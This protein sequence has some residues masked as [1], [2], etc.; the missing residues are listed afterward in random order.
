MVKPIRIVHLITSLDVGGAEMMLYRLLACLKRS[1]YESR[2]ISLLPAGSVGEKIAEQGVPVLSL[3]M[4]PGQP[5]LGAFS[6]LV[7]ELRQFQP[8]ILQTWLYHADLMGL[9]AG[10]LAG[11]PD[12]IWN[13]RASDADMSRYR[14]LSGWT[15]RACARLASRPRAVITNS[16]A[17]RIHHEKIGY[18]PR[19]WVLISNGVDIERFKPDLSARS[20]VR[21][22][23]GLDADTFLIGYIARYDPLKDHLTFL[24]AAGH[25]T[26]RYP[27]AHFL[28][29]GLNISWDNHE[30]VSFIDS[31]RLRPRVHLLGSRDD[32]PRI[33]AALDIATSASISEGFSNV[34]V[35][36][37]ACGVPCV[38]TNV[39]DSADIVGETGV[40]VQP[41]DPLALAEGWMQLINASNAEQK[42]LGNADRQRVR[43]RF[44]LDRITRQYEDLYQNIVLV[45]RMVY[46]KS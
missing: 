36:A 31:N 45:R 37:M 25:L 29:C 33:T 20:A 18:K 41:S 14:P 38:V 12:V 13:L 1:N 4:A 39:G 28:L 8:D 30:L 2:V 9:F 46:K 42:K 26:E 22:E 16:T 32:I 5:S 27:D 34:I 17:G 6:R 15:L 7:K 10:R 43:Q 40:V 44:S 24:R 35:E 11:V 21:L 23:L 19:R 3:G